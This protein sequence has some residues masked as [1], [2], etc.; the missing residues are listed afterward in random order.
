[1]GLFAV[2]IANWAGLIF[3]ILEYGLEFLLAKAIQNSS[4]IFKIISI[5]KKR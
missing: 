2:Y 4:C 1:M 5:A 3:G